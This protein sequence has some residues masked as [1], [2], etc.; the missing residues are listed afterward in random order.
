MW[1]ISSQ[2]V[3]DSIYRNLSGLRRF[4]SDEKIRLNPELEGGGT[5]L[6]IA[7]FLV[8]LYLVFASLFGISQISCF[9]ISCVA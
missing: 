9:L 7:L 8:L 3:L 4:D 5:N 6:V 1:K 2:M